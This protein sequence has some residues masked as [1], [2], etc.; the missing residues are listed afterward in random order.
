MTVPVRSALALALLGALLL[1]VSGCGDTVI[2]EAKT[3]EAIKASLEKSLHEKIKT[4]DC[5]SNVKVE[6]GKTF[7]CTVDF[8]ESNEAI[9]TLKIR[10][11]D[12]DVSLV[13]LKASKAN[14]Q[15]RANE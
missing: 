8:P 9:A 3:E 1:V 7:S 11:S 15:D 14:A 5:P 4:V 10:D 13:G 2:D 6:A 12:A